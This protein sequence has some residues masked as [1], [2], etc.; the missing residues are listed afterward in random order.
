VEEIGGLRTWMTGAEERL[1]RYGRDRT[2]KYWVL[3]M[4]TKP[5]FFHPGSQINC[6]KD[7][8]I[9]IHI[10]E[11]KYSD[12]KIV[13]KLSKIWSV[14]FIPDP[15]LHFLSIPDPGVKKAPDPGSG[16]ATLHSAVQ[17]CLWFYS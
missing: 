17:N 12:P 3:N 15:D 2:W 8:R 9:R 7:S 14:K 10:K 13:S 11:L 6:Q 16:S 1:S 5:I 4:Y